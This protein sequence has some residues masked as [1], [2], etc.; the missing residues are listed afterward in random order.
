MTGLVKRQVAS[1]PFEPTNIADEWYSADELPDPSPLPVVKGWKVLVRPLSPAK[2]IG[3]L[4]VP[5]NAVQRRE[6]VVTVGRVLAYGPLAWKRPDMA[7]FDEDDN[8]KPWAE[9]GD[10]VMYPKNSPRRFEYGK[11]KLIVLQDDEII[12]T[13][14][15][16]DKVKLGDY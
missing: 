2:K 3:N 10:Y 13:I 8:W 16:P 9:V 7:E 11:V 4:W 12:L 15:D 14:P 1:N 6:Y 5:P